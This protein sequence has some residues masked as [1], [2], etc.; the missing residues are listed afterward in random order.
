MPDDVR[1]GELV[2]PVAQPQIRAR[3]ARRRTGWA[4][5][6]DVDAATLSA[7][8]FDTRAG[9]K[10]TPAGLVDPDTRGRD[11]GLCDPPAMSARVAPDP[12][13]VT[14]GRGSH[15]GRCYGAASRT[16]RYR[17][18]NAN[19]AEVALMSCACGNC[20]GACCSSTTTKPTTPKPK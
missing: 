15:R 10:G 5:M 17:D 14:I 3:L 16:W 13:T 7:R 12:L 11:R 19:D 18:A 20:C 2:T 6:V 1:S 4:Q 8:A 9:L